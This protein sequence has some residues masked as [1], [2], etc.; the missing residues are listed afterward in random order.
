MLLEEF[1]IQALEEVIGSVATS[2]SGDQTGV[3]IG[4]SSMQIGESPFG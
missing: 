4:E 1:E 2:H 3:W